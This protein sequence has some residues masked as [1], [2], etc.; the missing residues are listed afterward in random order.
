MLEHGNAI[1]PPPEFGDEL[2]EKRG[3]AG[4]GAADDRDDGRRRILFHRQYL[5]IIMTNGQRRL[6]TE[7]EWGDGAA[8][9]GGVGR[10]PLAIAER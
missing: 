9:A 5:S 7:T 2:G 6:F 4:S 8:M 10:A 1:P 3:L